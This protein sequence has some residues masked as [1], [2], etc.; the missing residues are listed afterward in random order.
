MQGVGT[1]GENE[2]A[3]PDMIDIVGRS[4]FQICH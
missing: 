4:T 1:R 3:W 2:F